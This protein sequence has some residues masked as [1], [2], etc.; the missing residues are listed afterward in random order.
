MPYR[1]VTYVQRLC[2]QQHKWSEC[3]EAKMG[4]RNDYRWGSSNYTW[5]LNNSGVRDANYV[6]E[7]PCITLNPQNLTTN[8]LLSTGSLTDNINIFCL[9]HELCTVFFFEII[10]I[11]SIIAGLQC[12]FSTVQQIDPVTHTYIHFFLTLSSIKLQ[13]KWLDI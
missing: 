5:L 10:F 12:Q 9:L 6:F 1:N 11:F 3:K 2:Q 8:S 13:N 7:N 4:W